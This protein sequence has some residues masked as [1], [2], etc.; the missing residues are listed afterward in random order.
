[1]NF[2]LFMA[3]INPIKHPAKPV[4]SIPRYRNGRINW[5]EIRPGT[6]LRWE[7][8]NGYSQNVACNVA[9]IS[10]TTDYIRVRSID[11]NHPTWPMN[12]TLVCFRSE[13]RAS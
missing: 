2:R 12:T 8:S 6:V 1:M 4:Q 13:L 3:K 10:A 11:I 5:N 9:F 7:P